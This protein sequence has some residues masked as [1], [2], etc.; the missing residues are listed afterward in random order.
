MNDPQKESSTPISREMDEH[1]F[2]RSVGGAETGA[3]HIPPVSVLSFG[4]PPHFQ[5]AA[6]HKLKNLGRLYRLQ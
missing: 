3:A 1:V 2:S 6:R 5:L 4:F